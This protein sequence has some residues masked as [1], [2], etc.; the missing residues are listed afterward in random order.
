MKLKKFLSTLCIIVPM[1]MVGVYLTVGN[2]TSNNTIT[3][4]EK[5]YGVYLLAFE[6]GGY[7]GTYNEWLAEI[8][9]DQ[10]QIEVDSTGTKIMWKYSKGDDWNELFDLSNVKGETGS[11]GEAGA[12]GSQGEAG[13]DGND[14]V[15]GNDGADGLS[16]YDIWSITNTDKTE[17]DFFQ[18]LSAYG[19][20]L[21]Q[22][23][24]AGKSEEDFFESLK[25][26]S[27]LK[28]VYQIYVNFGY[29]DT[30]ENFETA[31]NDGTLDLLQKRF[32]VTFVDINGLTI[33]DSKEV[34]EGKIVES[35]LESLDDKLGYEF[36]GW[37]CGDVK[38]EFNIY[39]INT[40][41]ELVA[42]Y[43]AIEYTINYDLDGG[44]NHYE[45]VKKI[46]IED[47]LV[48]TNP[49]KTG[50]TFLGWSDGYN[51]DVEEL[52]DVSSDVML[53]ALWETTQH[54][55]QYLDKDDDVLYTQIA[56]DLS[57]LTSPGITNAPAG[58]EFVCWQYES[59]DW[60]FIGYVVTSDMILTP[61]FAA[62]E[63]AI[64]YEGIT[65]GANHWLNPTTINIETTYKLYA[66]LERTGYT[67]DGWMLDDDIVTTLDNTTFGTNVV[68]TA[69]W[70][71]VSY[72]VI[73]ELDNG[74][75]VT[76]SYI[77]DDI[78]TGNVTLPVEFTEKEHYEV[79]AIY[80][81][82]NHTNVVEKLSNDL[83]EGNRIVL[84]VKFTIK[85]YNDSTID[86][87]Y[88]YFGLDNE[89]L[90]LRWNL[91]YKNEN[92]ITVYADKAISAIYDENGEAD[93]DT[94]TIVAWLNTTFL[95]NS[96][97]S[98]EK[99]SLSYVRLYETSYQVNLLTTI[100]AREIFKTTVDFK[101]IGYFLTTDSQQKLTWF[102]MFN[103][104]SGYEGVESDISEVQNMIPTL[105][106]NI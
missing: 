9:G 86:Q 78:T 36:G 38:W 98:S 101:N 12:D 103:F 60:S 25:G 31:Y 43:T 57:K 27:G 11:Q 32:T 58:Y 26:E 44:T 7:T 61:K 24:N 77:Y 42:K 13:A 92:D 35:P 80:R 19:I 79:S 70:S 91:I 71:V 37:Y 48:L 84:Y 21:T 2:D 96:F 51:N 33:S 47:T 3:T 105:T 54:T 40:D 74:L 81:N 106:I 55:I 39:T 66:P 104:D 85:I 102:N 75:S 100:E 95:N 14:G 72:E 20:W 76:S 67:F 93:Y 34:I 59:E 8:S 49:T 63:Y 16:A 90:D 15:D 97:S 65:D 82:Y 53:T 5:V 30:Y 45:N 23:G 1:L 6:Q 83:I 52:S 94:S 99:T 46:T 22:D 41:I 62:K 18:S 10:I 29:T 50:F 28:A 73:Y 56:A 69:S 64:S 4:D 68:L 87:D 88:V 89:G 17:E